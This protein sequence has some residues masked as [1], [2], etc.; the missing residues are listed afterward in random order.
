MAKFL[1]LE[2]A[3]GW[4]DAGGGGNGREERGLWVDGCCGEQDGWRL[5]PRKGSERM[6]KGLKE[7][8]AKGRE[9]ADREGR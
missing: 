4:R 5:R 1:L 3:E 7:K 2:D 8:E 6:R 9:M